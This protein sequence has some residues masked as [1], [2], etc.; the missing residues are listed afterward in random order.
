[1]TFRCNQWHRP[2]G[3]CRHPAT[4]SE[5]NGKYYSQCS[6]GTINSAIAARAFYNLQ[7]ARPV[8]L[9]V[10]PLEISLNTWRNTHPL[11]VDTRP[12]RGT[13]SERILRPI[14]ECA[15]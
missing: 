1:M 9:G 7:I 14:P 3:T 4:T 6:R 2:A 11:Q 5:R 12:T 8:L 15:A 10:S 13:F